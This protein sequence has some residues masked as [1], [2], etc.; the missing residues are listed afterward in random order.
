[1]AAFSVGQQ[2]AIAAWSALLG[3]IALAAI[4]NVR[5]FKEVIRRGKE[6][7]AAAKAGPPAPGRPAPE[8]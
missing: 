7:R 1:V 5:S 2:I 8:T 6:A 4:F 3:F